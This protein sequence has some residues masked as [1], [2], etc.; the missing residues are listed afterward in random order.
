[1]EKI[2]KFILELFGW[3]KLLEYVW[4]AVH[5]ILQELASKTEE[6]RIDDNIVKMLDKMIKHVIGT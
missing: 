1:M 4:D 6:T 2:I 3:K 5:P